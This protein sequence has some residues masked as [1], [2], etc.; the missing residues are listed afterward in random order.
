MSEV[1]I[2]KI[3]I[4]IEGGN[5]QF[6][7]ADAPVDIVVLDNDL[8]NAD[9]STIIV[10]GVETPYYRAI[11]DYGDEECDDFVIAVYKEV[12][13]DERTSEVAEGLPSRTTQPLTVRSI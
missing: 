1:N 11:V 4:E 6:I 5:I 12:E 8:D 10:D 3:V 2:P 9:S 7:T 13:E